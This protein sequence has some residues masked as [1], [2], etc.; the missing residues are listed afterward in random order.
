ML[1]KLTFPVNALEQE[2]MKT[3]IK[4]SERRNITLFADIHEA[5]CG[6]RNEN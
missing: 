5:L 3:N 2:N 1:T 6:H 4:K